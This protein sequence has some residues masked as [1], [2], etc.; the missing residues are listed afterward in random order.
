MK[1]SRR[2]LLSTL[3]TVNPGRMEF[4][5]LRN[6][7]ILAGIF[8]MSIIP[9][10]LYIVSQMDIFILLSIP[11]SSFGT[12]TIQICAILLDRDLRAVVRTMFRSKI[13]VMPLANINPT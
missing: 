6:I 4:E 3:N 9:M 13:R 10:V 12:M 5:L 11:G 7:L 1:A 2:N 8:I